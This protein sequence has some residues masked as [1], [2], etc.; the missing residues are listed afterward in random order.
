MKR[1]PLVTLAKAEARDPSTDDTKSRFPLTQYQNWTWE[2]YLRL[3]ETL[4]VNLMRMLRQNAHF[5]LPP[6]SGD[7]KIFFYIDGSVRSGTGGVVTGTPVTCPLDPT[8]TTITVTITNSG[9]VTAVIPPYAQGIATTVAGSNIAVSGTPVTLDNLTGATSKTFTDGITLTGTGLQTGTFIITLSGGIDFTSCN[10]DGI[11]CNAM[12]FTD[13]VRVLDV[14]LNLRSCRLYYEE[15]T[16][17]RIVNTSLYAPTAT[18]PACLVSGRWLFFYPI[19]TSAV[20]GSFHYIQRPLKATW[21]SETDD[22]YIDG[23]AQYLLAKMVASM[24]FATDSDPAFKEVETK[25]NNE[26]TELKAKFWKE[27][28][29]K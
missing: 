21:D 10:S 27:V 4:P 3:V 15:E 6:S 28:E 2:C 18:D 17:H 13:C 7:L 23:S 5:T 24:K 1:T 22:C 29:V 25:L 20:S 16:F 19:S 11:A 12:S 26:I 8:P 9:K 14:T